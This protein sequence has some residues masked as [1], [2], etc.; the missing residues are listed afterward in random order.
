MSS[1]I[2]SECQPPKVNGKNIV[3]SKFRVARDPSNKPEIAV[4]VQF[5]NPLYE[6]VVKVKADVAAILR[7]FFL[8]PSQHFDWRLLIRK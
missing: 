4:S 5:L 1:L 6:K 3:G 2:C 7:T 8:A